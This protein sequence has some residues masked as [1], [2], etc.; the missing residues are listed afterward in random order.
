MSTAS[1]TITLCGAETEIELALTLTVGD[2]LPA[3]T[4]AN[5][6]DVLLTDAASSDDASELESTSVLSTLLL[7]PLPGCVSSGNSAW[8]DE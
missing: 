8:N 2:R 6:L 3:S 5:V 4:F 7:P 1:A